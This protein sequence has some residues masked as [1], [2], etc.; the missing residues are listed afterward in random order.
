MPRIP[1]PFRTPRP[2]G[3][4]GIRSL[5]VLPR[6]GVA[7]AAIA[8]SGVAGCGGG[9][10]SPTGPGGPSGGPISAKVNGQPWAA[11]SSTSQAVTITSLPGGFIVSGTELAPGGTGVTYSI[12]LTL[13]NVSGPGDYQLGVSSTMFGGIAIAASPGQGWATPLSGDAGRVT[14]TALAADR[15]AGTFEFTATS[16]PAGAGDL[17]VTEGAFDL[18]LPGDPLLPV[19]TGAGSRLAATIGGQEWYAATE[20]TSTAGSHFILS[21][22]NVSRSF[23]LSVSLTGPGTFALGPTNSLTISQ[24]VEGGVCC[25]GSTAGATGT[26][27][28]TT[29]GPE[30][31][32]GSIEATL[33]P[34]PGT[35]ATGDLVVT[36]CTFDLGLQ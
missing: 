15:I 34:S 3:S 31:V 21:A 8:V 27:T 1:T 7:L 13:Y 19:A 36:G 25:W 6:I 35:D 23:A 10:G 30:R 9:D 24:G 18:P 26:L 5:A 2:R 12:T 17:V 14:I 16:T 22:N 4:R 20:V 11:S 29:Y 28:I 32:V 33:V